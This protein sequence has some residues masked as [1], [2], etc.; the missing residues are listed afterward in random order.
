[1]NGKST[2]VALLGLGLVAAHYKTNPDGAT[3]KNA[4][5]NVNGAP[6]QASAHTA[7]IRMFGLLAGVIILTIASSASDTAG[8]FS[9]GFFLLLWVIWGMSNSAAITSAQSILTNQPTKK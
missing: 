9:I 5:S 6:A 7:F 8:T 2:M 3:I 4:I 1:M